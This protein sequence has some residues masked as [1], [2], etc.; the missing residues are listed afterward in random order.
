MIE[1]PPRPALSA[2]ALRARVGVVA[3]LAA[4]LVGLCAGPA[5]AVSTVSTPSPTPSPTADAGGV[6][7]PGAAAFTLSPISGG[8]L[9]AGA[10]LTVSVTMTNG[11]VTPTTAGS[12]TLGFGPTALA[13]RD[14]LAEWLAGDGEADTVDVASVAFPEVEPDSDLTRGVMVE[15]AGPVLASLAPGVYPVVATLTTADES[16]TST[17]A[18]VVPDEAAPAGGVGVV[19]PVTADAT[20][21][22]L[23]TADELVELMGPEGSLTNI[24]DAVEGT[25]AILAIDPAIPAAIRVLGTAVPETVA[26]WLLRLEELAN[27]RFA[28]QFG[29]ADVSA[30]VQAG[31]VP[32]LGP[33]SLQSFMTPDAFVPV[34]APT[35]TPSASP[36]A[37][38]TLPVYPDLATL[39]G[40]GTA[41]AAT[42]WP[43]TGTA[44]ADVVSALGGITVD[45]V[46]GL[47]LIPSTTTAAGADG[48]TVTA[49][50]DADGSPVLVYDGVVSQELQAA[51]EMDAAP[52]RGAHLA[53][54]TS[55]LAFALDDARGAPL[56]VTVDRGEDRSRVA[57]RTSITTA[58]ATPSAVPESLDT[59]VAAPGQQVEV[60]DIAADEVRAGAASALLADE[61]SLGQFATI[62]DDPGLITQPERAEILQLLG[63]AW[64]PEPALWA[65]ALAEHRADSAATL[66]SVGILRAS[67]IQLITSGAVIPVWVRNDLPYPANVTLFA[68][69]DDLRLRVQQ[70]TTVVAQPQS[71]TRVE[72]PVQAQLGS[73]DVMIALELR[74]PTG[75]P[76]GAPQTREVHVRAEW[77]GIGLIVIGIFGVG[78]LLLGVIRMVLRRR[79][80]GADDAGADGDR[81][82]AATD[83]VALGTADDALNG[84][85]PATKDDA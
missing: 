35:P 17:S 41:R 82:S 13:D 58:L 74:S 53:A 68:T 78:F 72:V 24:L 2:R 28:L 50:G 20:G 19:V 36:T 79:R 37:D 23:L 64:R 25:D 11:R 6:V 48:S 44:G 76:I 33:T 61:D 15:E 55:Y 3:G 69:P 16:F 47:T 27:T 30:Q 29:D 7:E 77:E 8:V 42:F 39:L 26:L 46:Q 81:G 40:V 31:I 60:L 9:H 85:T 67:P 59:L 18:V 4:L 1:S 45:E 21:E 57:L 54:A 10:P 5:T 83:D 32:P 52:L 66:D 84:G 65:A 43:A 62:L 75:V 34:P 71:N 12:V 73:G 14:E 56:L 63:N 70:T 22:A 38:P 49:R 51:S 80:R